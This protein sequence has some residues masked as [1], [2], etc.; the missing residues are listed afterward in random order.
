M[1][2]LERVLITLAVAIMLSPVFSLVVLAADN[3][4]GGPP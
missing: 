1:R 3:Q 2:I 4:S